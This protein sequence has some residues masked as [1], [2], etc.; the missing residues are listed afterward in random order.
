[1]GSWEGAATDVLV[2]GV[3]AEIEVKERKGGHR[4]LKSR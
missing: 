2:I 3:S 4:V 1:M